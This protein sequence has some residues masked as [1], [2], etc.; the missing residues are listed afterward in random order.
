MKRAVAAAIVFVL[1][2]AS[3]RL[4]WHRS[5]PPEK[6]RKPLV[7]LEGNSEVDGSVN[8]LG[9]QIL[10]GLSGSPETQTIA[11]TGETVDQYIEQVATQMRP[12]LAT[13]SG[14]VVVATFDAT[15]SYG[16]TGKSG[17]EVY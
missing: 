2:V 8:D 15:N 9:A 5:T 1:L 3:L 16:L 12:L 6:S 4:A 17:P 7:I 14:V 10:A 11:A 13:R